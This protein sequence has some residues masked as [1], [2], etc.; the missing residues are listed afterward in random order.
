[1]HRCSGC[2]NVFEA[3]TNRARDI[4][5]KSLIKRRAELFPLGGDFS[6]FDLVKCPKCDHVE[7]SEE[8]RIFGLIPGSSR[9]I[10][11]VLFAF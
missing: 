2:Q 9:N 8:L 10:K 4:S 6:S 5:W 11:L 1:L 3:T 7:K